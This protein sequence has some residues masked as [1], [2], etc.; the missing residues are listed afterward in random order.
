[1][2]GCENGGNSALTAITTRLF[3]RE[4]S[5]IT[6]AKSKT[7]KVNMTVVRNAAYSKR[8]F[9]VRERHNE[10]KNECYGNGDIDL[11]RADLNVHFLQRI[12]NLDGQPFTYEQIFNAMLAG[13]EISTHGLKPDAH[14]FDEMIFDVNT[15]YFEERGGYE[16]AKRFYEE[17]Y[18]CAV[19]EVRGEQFILSAVMH[20]DERNKEVS[21]R[22]GRDVYHYH[23]HVIYIPVVRKELY[24]KKNNK[25]PELAGKLKEVITQ[26]SHSKKWPIKTPVE[27]DGKKYMVN[28][29]SLLQDRFFEH[30]RLAGFEGFERGE[31]G[32]TREHLSD[33][34]YKVQQE[35]MRL[36]EVQEEIKETEA[37][38]AKAERTLDKKTAQVEKLDKDVAVKTKAAATVKEIDAMGHTIPL[39]PGVHFTDEEAVKLKALAKKS[40]TAD[41]RIA[42][43]KKKMAAVE[44]QLAA[45]ERK[46]RDAQIEAN[47]WHRELT[48]LQREVKPYLNA[49]REFPQ[50]MLELVKTLFPPVK[51]QEQT[52]EIQPQ[53]KKN[54]DIG[55]R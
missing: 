41:D 18:R 39:I 45:M 3:Y 33:T 53:R 29:Y 8:G 40:V 2:G 5:E 1:M 9:N 11:S 16:Y 10:R 15:E 47:H 48:D 43:N 31:V 54:H 27:K 14:V 22:L 26:V 20:A 32:S 23:L 4:R 38:L 50:K 19:K 28:A 42:A 7:S 13:G 12:C 46:F 37:T 52:Q 44:E 21:E 55:G 17:A 34:E 24:F 35:K 36:A 51:Q 25:N 49:I 30:M 6:M